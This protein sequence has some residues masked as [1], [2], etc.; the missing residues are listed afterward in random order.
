MVWLS[1]N[2]PVFIHLRFGFNHVHF[3]PSLVNL[4]RTDLLCFPYNVKMD[5]LLQLYSP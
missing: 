1:E 2:I 4:V 3:E 5:S